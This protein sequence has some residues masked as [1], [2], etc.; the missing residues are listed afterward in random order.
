M[1]L[2]EYTIY[3]YDNQEYIRFESIERNIFGVKKSVMRFIPRKTVYDLKGRRIKKWK[4]NMFSTEVN[5]ENKHQLIC[6]N[7]NEKS[8]FIERFPNIQQYLNELNTFTTFY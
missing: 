4:F 5:R 7:K 6:G 8:D 3:K 1:N 2:T